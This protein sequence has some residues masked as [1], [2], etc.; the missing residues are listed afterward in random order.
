[1]TLSIS[2]P[3][4]FSILSLF[5]SFKYLLDLACSGSEAQDKNNSKIWKLKFFS[6]ILIS[7]L[8]IH[9]G[10]R[11]EI[12]HQAKLKAILFLCQLAPLN[13]KHI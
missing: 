9:F 2:F 1:M 7:E 13:V 10:F 3:K 4:I 8:L 11:S 12:S 5:S 6:F